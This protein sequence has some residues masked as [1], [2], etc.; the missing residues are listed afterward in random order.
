M[1]LLQ[2]CT[3]SL[4]P[5]ALDSRKG[6]PFGGMKNSFVESYLGFKPPWSTTPEPPRLGEVS[7]KSTAPPSQTLCSHRSLSL[8]G[9]THNAKG[10]SPGRELSEYSQRGQKN[11][12]WF[13]KSAQRS[14]IELSSIY[15]G[16]KASMVLS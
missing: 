13:G 16:I 2:S 4:Q 5:R 3:R 6:S 11:E 14:W 1:P 9:C 15:R 8:A 7:L 10:A 12:D